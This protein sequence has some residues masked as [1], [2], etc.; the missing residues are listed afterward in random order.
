MIEDVCGPVVASEGD[1]KRNGLTAAID[2]RDGFEVAVAESRII[3]AMI[4]GRND[5]AIRRVPCILFKEEGWFYFM[6]F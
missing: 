1:R 6:Y 3:V 2:H 4:I 5:E